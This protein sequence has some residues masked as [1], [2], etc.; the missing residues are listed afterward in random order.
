MST[1]NNQLSRVLVDERA[2]YVRSVSNEVTQR[3][4]AREA[5][6]DADFK[7]ILAAAE[8]CGI[9]QANLARQVQVSRSTVARW[10]SGDSLP[11]HIVRRGVAE[12]LGEMLRDILDNSNAVDMESAA[13]ISH[14]SREHEARRVTKSKADAS[15]E[16]EGSKL[17][18]AK[19]EYIMKSY[20]SSSGCC[21]VGLYNRRMQPLYEHS[22]GDPYAQLIQSEV[23]RYADIADSLCS[24]QF[25]IGHTPGLVDGV[26]MHFQSEFIFSIDK[27]GTP[28]DTVV[29]S[30]WRNYDFQQ[31]AARHGVRQLEKQLYMAR[32]PGGMMK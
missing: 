30:A 8:A 18:S 9:T 25:N 16:I 1:K 28:A 14:G 3:L 31:A 12:T 13:G 5:L 15:M 21:F 26:T 27:I 7:A 4:T 23:W 17:S 32:F 24:N 22:N 6:T 20:F 19:L 11:S 29:L 2:S 10:S